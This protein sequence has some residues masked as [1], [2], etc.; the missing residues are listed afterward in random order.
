MID[1][2]ELLEWISSDS[3]SLSLIYSQNHCQRFS[4]PQ[5]SGTASAGVEALKI[6]KSGFAE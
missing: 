6:L 5:I 2:N 1:D 3:V 4:P